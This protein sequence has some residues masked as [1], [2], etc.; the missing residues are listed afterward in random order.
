MGESSILAHNP[1][2]PNMQEQQR[3]SIHTAALGLPFPEHSLLNPTFTPADF[4]P[5]LPR[6]EPGTREQHS[7]SDRNK[8]VCRYE[9]ML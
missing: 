9:E 4:A 1:H 6:E 8:N 7:V 3:R 5:A 2:T